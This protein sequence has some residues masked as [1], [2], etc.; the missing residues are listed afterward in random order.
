MQQQKSKKI[1]I[2]FFLFLIIGTLNNKNLNK[3]N[4]P[5]INSITIEGLDEK[6]NQELI[7]SLNFLKTK[8][9]FFL[10][11]IKISKIINSNHLVEEYS[12]FKKYPST[13]NI[14][15]DK[16]KFLAQIK[17]NDGNFFLGSNGKLIKTKNLK[18]ELPFIYGDFKIKNF[19]ELEKAI[20]ESNFNFKDIKNLFYFPSG[21]WDIETK[22]GLLIKLSKNELEKSIELFLTILDENYFKDIYKIDLRQS[23][24]IVING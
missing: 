13:L 11:R 21:R 7:D 14:K 2:Y 17:K 9:L 16:T 18:K 6:N 12:V 3:A 22:S 8:N 10:N 5:T 4:I 19:F 1:F 23:N 15:I 20:N 24:Q